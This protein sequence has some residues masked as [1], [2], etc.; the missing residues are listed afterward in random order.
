MQ[1]SIWSTVYGFPI[2]L[3]AVRSLE[4]YPVSTPIFD[5]H[6]YPPLEYYS[7][8]FTTFTPVPIYKPTNYKEPK[9]TY[10]PGI[11]ERKVELKMKSLQ[12]NG[13]VLLYDDI[14]LRGFHGFNAVILHLRR[15]EEQKLILLAASRLVYV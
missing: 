14:A 6:S 1:Y 15:V 9:G 7:E 5:Y 13:F 10:S 12:D 4:L 3:A 8:P 2:A 11:R